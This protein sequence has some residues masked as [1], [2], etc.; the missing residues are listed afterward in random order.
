MV[1]KVMYLVNKSIPTCL[2]PIRELAKH[3]SHP[4]KLHWKGLTRLIGYIKANIG[5]GRFLMKPNEL[6]IIAYTDSDYANNDER[7]SITGGIVTL[8]G[9]PTYFMS[10]MQSIVSLSSTE[11][12]YIALGTITQ[13]V[14]FQ[15]QI[16][17]ELLDDKDEKTSIIYEDNLGAIYL[18]K[19][20]QISQR[21]K[22]IDVRHHFIRNLV[23]AKVIDVKYI[24]SEDNVADILTKSVKEEIFNKHANTINKGKI[25]YEENDIKNTDDQDIQKK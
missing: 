19:N 18:A 10:K 4:T 13:E 9:S 3:C 7:K 5:K 17:N 21:T 6:R 11:A 24:K 25:T 1:G 15:R 2:S 16:L 20:Q 8:G 22:H 23:E 12:E 14:L